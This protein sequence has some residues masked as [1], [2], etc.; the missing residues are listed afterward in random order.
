VMPAV[1][2]CVPGH[3]IVG[4]VT[5]VGAGVSKFKAGDLVGIG[6]LLDSDQTCPNCRAC[7]NSA[8]T[9][10]SLTAVPTSTRRRRSPMAVTPTA[11]S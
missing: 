5:Q 9:R 8:R 7:S 3:Q 10:C 6:C 4:R 2:P 11:S 1:Y